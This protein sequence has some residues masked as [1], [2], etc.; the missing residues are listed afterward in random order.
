LLS[1]AQPSEVKRFSILD[2]K[3]FYFLGN[4]A[5]NL[6]IF[7]GNQLFSAMLIFIFRL[8]KSS[9]GRRSAEEDAVVNF[10]YC[11]ILPNAGG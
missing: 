5:G 4:P 10:F 11:L 8:S 6:D 9:N 3:M 7:I 1:S 2:I